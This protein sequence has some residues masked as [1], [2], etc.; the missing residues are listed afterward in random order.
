MNFHSLPTDL[1][2]GHRR[3]IEEYLAQK[4]SPHFGEW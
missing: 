1:A 4:P 3:R 2:A